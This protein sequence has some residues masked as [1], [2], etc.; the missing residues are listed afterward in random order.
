MD[1]RTGQG[2]ATADYKLCQV[3]VP[4]NCVNSRA[5]GEF[6]TTV[7]AT[8]ISVQISSPG[9]LKTTYTEKNRPFITVKP[10]E[11]RTLVVRLPPQ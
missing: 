7:P 3:Q 2:I 10:G 4:E 6:E 1:E 5:V 11:E 8:E 9:Y